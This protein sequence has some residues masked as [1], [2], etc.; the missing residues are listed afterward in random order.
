[1]QFLGIFNK[2]GCD[3]WLKLRYPERV[4]NI[5]PIR[6]MYDDMYY[7][8]FG[9]LIDVG[10]NTAMNG[11]SIN[12]YDYIHYINTVGS[13][14]K[15]AVIYYVVPDSHDIKKHF[16][17]ATAILDLAT[18]K[19]VKPPGLPIL[20]L[21]YYEDYKTTYKLF[22]MRYKDVFGNVIIGLPARV[23]TARHHNGNTLKI[24]CRF[25]PNQC[26]RYIENTIMELHRDGFRHYHVL[27]INRRVYRW[28]VDALEKN[29][30]I[31]G[32]GINVTADT[33]N[34][35]LAVSQKLRVRDYGRGKYMVHDDR[36]ACVWFNEWLK[37]GD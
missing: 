17:Y 31:G 36:Y 1:M 27:G 14:F 22:L 5:V 26:I 18:R 20:V 8:L 13:A 33:D 29:D 30:G 4:R 7:M 10:L 24:P 25:K 9:V 32:L 6:R 23:L 3:G 21:H 2:D 19:K 34:Y 15:N 12:L 11:S 28:L 16:D 37:V 35:R